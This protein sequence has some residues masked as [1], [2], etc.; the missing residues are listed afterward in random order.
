MK[1]VLRITILLLIIFI[2]TYLLYLQ[3][4]NPKLSTNRLQTE[5]NIIQEQTIELSSEDI[6]NEINE[7]RKQNNLN[8]LTKYDPLCDLA[9]IRVY[10]IK[11]NWSH[12]GFED[13][14]DE[15]NEKYCNT[16][17][18]TCLVSGENLAKGE[19]SSAK[20][21]IEGWAASEGHR[22]NMLGE[23][24]VQCVASNDGY[25]VSL[26]AYTTEDIPQTNT[27]IDPNQSVSY[28][29]EKVRFWEKRKEE[30]KR[31]KD[32]WKKGYENPHYN[33]DLLDK[34]MNIFDRKID[35][36][37]TLWDGYTNSKIT[38][39]EAMDLQKDY[40][41]LHNETVDVTNKLNEEAYDTCIDY[42]KDLEDKNNKDY[43]KYINDCKQYV[44]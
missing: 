3:Q 19:F 24:N 18:L 42:W 21:L 32:S 10:E 31:Y 9:K 41:N 20:K 15:L 5:S 6:E 29:F 14:K 17:K 7:F 8:T 37:N 2:G 28:D 12:Q 25:F 33:T 11:D 40:W 23:Y 38:Y 27:Q 22:E 35:I 30:D 43:S 4:N 39:Q 44:D 13:R 36:A 1:R 16:E 26:F 34:L